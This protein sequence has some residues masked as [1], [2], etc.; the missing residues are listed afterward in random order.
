MTYERQYQPPAL[1]EDTN[2]NS[3][4]NYELNHNSVLVQR[5]TYERQ[6]LLPA[7]LEEAV[8]ESPHIADDAGAYTQ[9][10]P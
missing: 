9:T 5:M 3:K 2:T 7:L 10:N 6:Y 8:K 4:L 1:V